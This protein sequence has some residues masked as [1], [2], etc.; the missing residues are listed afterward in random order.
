MTDGGATGAR[1][2]TAAR[3]DTGAPA[4]PPPRWF[5]SNT[6]IA[7][8]ATVDIFVAVVALFFLTPSVATWWQRRRLAAAA[9]EFEPGPRCLRIRELREGDAIGI[10]ASPPSMTVTHLC[11]GMSVGATRAAAD[12]GLRAGGFALVSSWRAEDR[13][14][15]DPEEVSS[16]T[17][18]GSY[19]IASV[20]RDGIQLTLV[21]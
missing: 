4:G 11:A 21:R 1:S 17:G 12:A 8:V 3:G 2:S 20:D 14:K 7:V 18:H 19:V 5:R 9:S 15:T 13:A 10:F 16:W 6:F